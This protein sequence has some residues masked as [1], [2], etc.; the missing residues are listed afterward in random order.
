V[1]HGVLSIVRV[2]IL[3][4]RESFVNPGLALVVPKVDIL[5]LSERS[6][7]L[8]QVLLHDIPGKA[9]DMNLGWGWG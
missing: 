3:D 4:V 9:T 1:L 5:D 8:L 6:E 2:G 7:D